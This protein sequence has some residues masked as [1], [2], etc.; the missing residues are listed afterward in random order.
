MLTKRMDFKTQTVIAIPSAIFGGIAGIWMAY[1][2]YGVWSLVYSAIVASTVK[3][4]QMWMYS[5]WMPSLKFEFVK[6][7]KHFD[8][9]YKLT[10]SDLLNRIFN[11]IFLIAIGKFFSPAQVGFYTR[12]ETMNQLPVRNISK[13]LEKVTFPL[14]VSIQNDKIRLKNAYKRILKTVVFVLTPF[15]IFLAVLAEP[16][17]RFLFTEKWLPAVPYFQIL[18]ITGIFFIR[19]MLQSGLS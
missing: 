12:A 6:F 5:N 17:F 16:I 13:T 9:G 14:F 11:N 19:F 18:C 10:I 3:T 2:G 8:Y 15:M 4:I 1:S 7:R